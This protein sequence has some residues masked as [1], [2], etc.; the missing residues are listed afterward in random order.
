[1]TMPDAP[2]QLT[3]TWTRLYR[4]KENYDVLVGEA[5]HFLYEYV[6]GMVKGLNPETGGFILRLRHP[7]ESTIAGR[8]RALVLVLLFMPT[9][10]LVGLQVVTLP[11]STSLPR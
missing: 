3:D 11:S 5:M 6:K 9:P 1:M 2:D 10:H 7:K 8:P 4:A